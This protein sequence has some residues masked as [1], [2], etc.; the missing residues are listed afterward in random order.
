MAFDFPSS[1]T[2]GQSYQVTGGPTYVWNGTAWQVL[3]PGSRFNRQVYTATAGQTTFNATYLIGGVDVFHNGVKLAPADFTASNGS[4]VVLVSAANAGDTIE[5]VSYSQVNYTN[6]VQKTGDTM[7]G[8]LNFSGNGLRITGDFSNATIANRLIF[9]TNTTNAVTAI[10]AIPSGTATQSNLILYNNSDPT[11][12]STANILVN[13]T[14]ARI[15]SGATGTGPAL[16]MTFYTGGSERAR[17]DTSGNVGIGTASP[18]TKLD[19]NGNTL[20]LNYVLPNDGY[21][22]WGVGDGSAFV[23]GNSSSDYV[24]FGTVGVERMRIDGSGN[25]GIG[26]SNIPYRFV[27]ANSTTDGAWLYSSGAQ[28]FLGLGGYA[29]STDGTFQIKYD[30]ATGVT[31]FS[32]VGRDAPTERARFTNGGDMLLG[33]TS[34][35][36]M[37]GTYSTR[38]FVVGDDRY[39]NNKMIIGC[40]SSTSGYDATIYPNDIGVIF[41]NNSAARDYVFVKNSG[42]VYGTVTAVINNVS[43]YRLKENVV[44]MNGALEKLSQVRPVNY[45]FKDGIE[46]K[47]PWG[48]ATVGGFIAHEL[49]A[50][51]PEAVYG[52][53]DAFYEDGKIKPQQ[54]DMTRLIPTL[55]GAV[56]ELKAKLDAAEARIAQ[57]EGTN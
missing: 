24:S 23:R 48:E 2:L 9:Q 31:S 34:T 35:P 36:T 45:N 12:A 55:V 20:A 5:I 16:P 8:N 41:N 54:V 32:S 13:A 30:R 21:L 53:K 22:Y 26:T 57:L 3:T 39:T 42:A 29:G 50:V 44:D 1:P 46:T 51:M 37:A 4:T 40:G 27:V 47:M 10:S 25:V 52:E 18:S 43:D 11:N 56:Q 28:S 38:F 33:T 17:I 7:T 15:N 14:E 6:A 19:V 49:Q